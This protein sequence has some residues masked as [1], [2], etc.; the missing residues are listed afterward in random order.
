MGRPLIIAAAL[1]FTQLAPAAPQTATP[2]A[3]LFLGVE[4]SRCVEEGGVFGQMGT[5]ICSISTVECER[6]GWKPIS[7]LSA[8]GSGKMVWVCVKP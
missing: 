2:P 6:K 3:A 7:K 1:T 4:L 5:A 8:S